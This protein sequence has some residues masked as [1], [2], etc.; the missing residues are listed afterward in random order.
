MEGNQLTIKIA[1]INIGIKPIHKG[2][3]EFCKDY[4]TDEDADF[5]LSATESDLEEEAV[6]VAQYE[7]LT[8]EI[9]YSGF[10]LEKIWV[11]R[12]I[13]ETIPKYDAFLIHAASVCV[14]G[15]AYLFLGPSGAGKTTH[16]KMWKQYFGD[17]MKIINDDKPLIRVTDDD[18]L[19]CGSPWSGKEN[20]KN[21]IDASL[22]GIA[23]LNQS[24]ENHIERLT[25]SDSWNAMMNQVYRSGVAETMQ[26]IFGLTDKV[27]KR[28]PLYSVD[29][30]KGEES[31]VVAYRTLSGTG[32]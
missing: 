9:D 17:R 4:L 3:E 10:E 25:V 7:N 18:I 19:V 20:W 32:I 22:K 12:Q 16:A 5:V 21:N 27:I 13:A 29:C 11:Y 26:K 30:T 15:E 8:A 6:R 28:I 24:N 1:D 14:D 2:F 23:C 31:V